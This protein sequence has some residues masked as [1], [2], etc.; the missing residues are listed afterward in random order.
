M[1]RKI[2]G[3]LVRSLCGIKSQRKWVVPFTNLKRN[4]STPSLEC[5]QSK[6]IPPMK[7]KF[8][9][10][11]IFIP[12]FLIG[13]DRRYKRGHCGI[14]PKKCHVAPSP[15]DTQTAPL[16]TCG[17]THSTWTEI[18]THST[19][20]SHIRIRPTFYLIWMSHSRHSVRATSHFLRMSHIRNYIRPTDSTHGSLALKAYQQNLYLKYYY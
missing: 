16:A 20:I 7:E 1:S 17:I 18:L 6:A 5:S 19:R 8:C 12:H 15:W 9:K 14:L 13:P 10:G 4:S 3:Q 2:S 11:N